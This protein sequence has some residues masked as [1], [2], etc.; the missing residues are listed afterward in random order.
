MGRFDLR[1]ISHF[2]KGPGSILFSAFLFYMAT[3]MVRVGFDASDMPTIVFLSSR[4]LLGY[5]LLLV[6]FRIKQTK[7][8][9]FVAVN[10][11]W[12]WHRAV[13][14]LIAV[15]FFYLGVIY[16][17][18]TGAN[19]LNMTYPAFVALFSIW[20]FSTRLTKA[21]FTGI[22]LA[23]TG[24][25]FISYNGEYFLPEKGDLFGLLSAITA[26]VAIVALKITRET[27]TT[28]VILFYTFRLGAWLTILPVIYILWQTPTYIR[29]DVLYYT[30]TS[31]LFG[32]FGQI[33]L[34]Y[35]YRF[36]KAVEG[37]IYS[38]SRLLFALLM[39]LLFWQKD[40]YLQSI[41]GAIL[42]LLANLVFAR[43]GFNRKSE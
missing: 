5:I 11:K 43:S 26:G 39:G 33:F 22:L 35:G 12:L 23:L 4:F 20:I 8:S 19:I 41:I 7:V 42:I 31:A 17:T 40:I 30:G 10:K 24:A 28:D 34:T 14:N 29:W 27:D 6:W 32:I 9:K 38:A 21:D 25:F 36:V 2:L 13:W 37:S 18:V 3:F 1:K 16:G 15:F